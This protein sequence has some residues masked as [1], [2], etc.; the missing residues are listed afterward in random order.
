MSLRRDKYPDPLWLT[1]SPHW[2]EPRFG[3]YFGKQD[4]RDYYNMSGPLH[5]GGVMTLG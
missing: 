1:L 3:M 2:P 4:V 5:N